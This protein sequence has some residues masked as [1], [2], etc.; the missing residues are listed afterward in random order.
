MNIIFLGA[1]GSGK[2]TQAAIVSEKFA[3]PALST[4]E[5]LRKEVANKTKVGELA[6]SYMKSGKLVP[7]EV[8]V[9]IIESRVQSDFPNGFILDGFPRN[10]AQAQILESMLLKIGKKIDVVFNFEVNEEILVKRICGR[11]SCKKC[12]A[13]YNKYFKLPSQEGVCDVCQ[14]SQFESRAD[15]NEETVKNRLKVYRESTHELIGFYQKKNLLISVDALK[16][17]PL[18][19]EDLK[20][21]ILNHTNNN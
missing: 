1:P 4:G 11:Y 6:E 13:I 10:I 3:I 8:V 18:I 19:F 2:G 21:E 5:S 15:D 17:A 20:K 7:D 12:G 16:S 14:S 9:E